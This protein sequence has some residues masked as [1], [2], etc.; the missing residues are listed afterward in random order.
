MSKDFTPVQLQIIGDLGQSYEPD[1]YFPFAYVSG[2]FT[3]P[4]IK[5]AMRD[6]RERGYVEFMRGS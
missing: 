6:L 4:E 1:I 5:A 3:R 2:G